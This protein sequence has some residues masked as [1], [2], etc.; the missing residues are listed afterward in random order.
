MILQ[1]IVGARRPLTVDEMAIALGLA[2]STGSRTTGKPRLNPEGL[3]KKIR[4]LCGLFIFINNS[5]VY[6]IHQTAREFLLSDG[7]EWFLERSDTET[8][9]SEICI[10][11]LLLDDMDSSLYQSDTDVLS[12][13]EYSAEYWPDHVRGMP[14]LA[15][16]KAE[17]RIDQLYDV[18]SAR[19]A[20]WFPMFW[21]A[22]K[23]YRDAPKMNSIRLAAFNGHKNVLWRLI[24]SN[25]RNIN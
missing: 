18:N 19:F 4:W 11:Y 10:N 13:L 2:K 25:E 22:V 21:R 5:R 23:K 9:L 3:G 14:L 8:L 24:L 6:L 1:I 12:F 17:T 16:S 20:L 7:Q 15:E